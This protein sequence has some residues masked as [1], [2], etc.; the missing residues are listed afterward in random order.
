M[1]LKTLQIRGARQTNPQIYN[2]KLKDSDN[3]KT[4]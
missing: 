3:K 1:R 2:I 4:V